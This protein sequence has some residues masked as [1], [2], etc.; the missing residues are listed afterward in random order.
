MKLG[1]SLKAA[2]EKSKK[3]DAYSGKEDGPSRK[4]QETKYTK[5]K[6]RLR[7]GGKRGVWKEVVTKGISKKRYDRISK[8]Y[9]KKGGKKEEEKH[10][11]MKYEAIPDKG[12]WRATKQRVEKET[13]RKK[14]GN[15]SVSKETRGNKNYYEIGVS[16][17]ADYR[18]LK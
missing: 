16:K 1:G 17:Q 11:E 12:S 15:K 13:V 14:K 4:S 7:G 2:A 18:K 6:E 9:K 5:S 10:K 3:K 8:R